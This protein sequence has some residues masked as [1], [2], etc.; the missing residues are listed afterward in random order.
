MSP[1]APSLLAPLYVLAWQAQERGGG[2][3]EQVVR[4][5]LVQER[6][7]RSWGVAQGARNDVRGLHR[8]FHLRGGIREPLPSCY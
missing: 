4:A 3:F 5:A 1:P 7:A 6:A 2:P 8:M